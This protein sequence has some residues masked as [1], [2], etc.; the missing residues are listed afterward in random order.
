MYID[1]ITDRTERVAVGA[2]L[3][4][5]GRWFVVAAARH[6]GTRWLVHFEGIDDRTA[7]EPLANLALLAD[8]L[9]IE[10]GAGDLYVHDLIGSEVVDTAGTSYGRCTSVLANPA[11]DILEL[12]DGSLVP[13]VFVVSAEPGR[14]VIDPPQGLFDLG[15]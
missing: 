11:H 4:V 6:A 3:Q 7:A 10:P 5:G 8:P 9:D 2:R 12:D 15:Q 13:V 14:V 1:L